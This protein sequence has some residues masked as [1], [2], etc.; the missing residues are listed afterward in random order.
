MKWHFPKYGAMHKEKMPIWG[1]PSNRWKNATCRWNRPPWHKKR[2]CQNHQSIYYTRS[3]HSQA[4]RSHHSEATPSYSWSPIWGQLAVCGK[5]NGSGIHI[6]CLHHIYD[7]RS[8]AA[9][10]SLGCLARNSANFKSAGLTSCLD[11]AVIRLSSSQAKSAALS[12]AAFC[13]SRDPIANQPK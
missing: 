4:T 9:L 7:F 6:S 11:S 2:P 3:L 10:L 5:L 12:P 8:D 13:I 1:T